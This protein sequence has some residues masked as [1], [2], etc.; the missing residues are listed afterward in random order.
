[1]EKSIL[2]RLV[3]RLYKLIRFGFY[4]LI[5]KNEGYFEGGFCVCLPFTSASVCEE[6]HTKH[7]QPWQPLDT[8][9][10]TQP[11]ARARQITGNQTCS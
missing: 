8:K 10:E 7:R 9:A 6:L 2:I 11:G 5:K 3:F 1:M 4:H